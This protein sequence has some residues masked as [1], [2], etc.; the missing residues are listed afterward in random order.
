MVGKTAYYRCNKVSFRGL[1]CNARLKLHYLPNSLNVL[2]YDAE[3]A[4]TCD[5]ISTKSR[6]LIPAETKQKMQE[7]FRLRVPPRIIVSEMEKL[8]MKVTTDQVYNYRTRY[9]KE[10]FGNRIEYIGELFDLLEQHQQD[11]ENPCDAFVLNHQINIDDPQ[12][13]RFHFVITSKILLSNA[14]FV[15]NGHICADGTYKLVWE[16]FNVLVVGSTDKSNT[17]HPFAIAG[18]TNETGSDYEYLFRSVKS[19]V[20]KYENITFSPKKLVS[21]AAMSIFNG[22]KEVFGQDTTKN[23]C[24]YHVTINVFPKVCIF[25]LTLRVLP[26]SHSKNVTVSFSLKSV[27]K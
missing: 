20:E 18:C 12:N 10:L 13:A 1:Q 27:L 6:E 17:F 5:N 25:V 16:D 23:T 8:N 21:D 22:F 7:F 4:H 24:F 14:R 11:P 3:N 2:R 19:G 9:N 15:R 26:K